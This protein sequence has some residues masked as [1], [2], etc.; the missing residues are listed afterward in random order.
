MTEGILCTVD[1]SDNS[2]KILGW[3]ADLAQKL[4]K[5]LTVLHTYRLLNRNEEALEMKRKLE[6]DALKKFSALEKDILQGKR[7][8][9]DFKSE[10]GFVSDRVKNRTKKNEIDLLVI[11]RNGYA[12]DSESLKELMENISAPVVIVP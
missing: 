9:Y 10:V 8:S 3:A 12:S 6:A 2:K 4:G 11:G 1:F 7:I 5:H